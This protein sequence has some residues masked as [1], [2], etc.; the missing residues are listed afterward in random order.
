MKKIL[1][2]VFIILLAIIGGLVFFLTNIDAIV[3][4]AIEK[5][6]S[7]V[8]ETSVR[9]DRVKIDLR[10]AAGGIYGLTIASPK[11]FDAKQALSLGETSLKLDIKKT[12]K[13][14]I[15]LDNVTVRAPH[16]NYEMNAAREGNLNKLYDNISKSMPAG[17]PGSKKSAEGEPKVIIRKF[18]F[19]GGAI[20]ARIV[21]VVN[22]SYSVKLPAMNMTNLGAPNGATGGQIAKEILSRITK[23][24]QDQVQHE[25]I[26]KQLKGVIEQQRKQVEGQA[27]EQIESQKKKVQE[28]AQEKL[29]EMLKH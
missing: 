19:E 22:K 29:K 3:K 21:P 20:D 15:V 14:L 5:Y 26:D 10:N 9:V 12:S 7:Q 2:V 8:T 17:S 6:G 27:K 25:I 18:V 4:G 24:A 1:I 28:Q 23:E 16:V 13:D 11:G